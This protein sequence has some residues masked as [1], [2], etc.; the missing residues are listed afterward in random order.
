[1]KAVVARRKCACSKCGRASGRSKLPLPKLQH[2]NLIGLILEERCVV[3]KDFSRR[4]ASW[5]WLGRENW[6]DS[7]EV[8]LC[9]L[10]DRRYVDHDKYVF[11]CRS[12]LSV[13]EFTYNPLFDHC[14]R[15]VKPGVSMKL[16]QLYCSIILIQVNHRTIACTIPLS[17]YF[18]IFLQAN[19]SKC[20]D[21][22]SMKV[23]YSS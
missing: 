16:L 1:M 15:A 3:V 9:S 7:G 5:Y 6:L 19:D 21:T 11:L 12:F 4:L 18:G 14:W 13:R 17:M 2:F 8:K 22:Q 10:A 20:N 23:Q